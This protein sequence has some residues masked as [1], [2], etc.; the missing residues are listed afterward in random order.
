MAPRGTAGSHD[1]AFAGG[2]SRSLHRRG[3][4]CGGRSVGGVAFGADHG[5]LG[6]VSGKPLWPDRI[7]VTPSPAKP[8][9]RQCRGLSVA[10]RR[11]RPGRRPPSPWPDGDREAKGLASAHPKCRHNAA[12]SDGAS[13]F[14]LSVPPR[15]DN[16]SLLL[17]YDGGPW[18]SPPLYRTHL[19]TCRPRPLL[20]THHPG[21]GGGEA[22]GWVLKSGWVG[23][24]SPLPSRRKLL[25]LCVCLKYAPLALSSPPAADDQTH[26]QREE[27]GKSRLGGPGGGEQ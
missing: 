5:P 16:A 7:T 23:P 2:K 18:G 20:G 12:V 15:H 9:S 26:S 17:G 27:K 3:G 21:G 8:W 11:A 13:G 4:V 24:V 1:D 19:F 22:N 6:P 10:G 25:A 14:A